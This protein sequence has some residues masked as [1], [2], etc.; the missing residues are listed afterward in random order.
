MHCELYR[1]LT[2]FLDDPQRLYT[3]VAEP[4]TERHHDLGP[5]SAQSIL[6]SDDSSSS[7]D[8]SSQS[9]SKSQGKAPMIDSH[10]IKS[11]R[12]GANKAHAA[13]STSKPAKRNEQVSMHLCS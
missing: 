1:L 8:E 11:N 5:S 6:S 7:E 10:G 4:E 12:A 3:N 9:R 13:C 2:L